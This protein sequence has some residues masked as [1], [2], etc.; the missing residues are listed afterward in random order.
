MV[1]AHFHR[2]LLLA[3]VP[4]P[5]SLVPPGPSRSPILLAHGA[6]L[7][8]AQCIA[9]AALLF[10]LCSAARVV[11]PPLSCTFPLVSFKL[12]SLYSVGIFRVSHSS[13]SPRHFRD[14]S[15]IPSQSCSPTIRPGRFPYL[16]PRGASSFLVLHP[17]CSLLERVLSIATF[18]SRQTVHLQSSATARSG[19]CSSGLTRSIYCSKTSIAVLSSLLL[20]TPR[21]SPSTKFIPTT[22]HLAYLPTDRSTRPS[23]PFPETSV[24][25]L[26]ATLRAASNYRFCK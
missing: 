19:P 11:G 1:C 25:L 12:F 21:H 3:S 14:P 16:C 22:F 23:S 18:F 10:A 5:S 20:P 9:A 15:W 24:A 4:V 8:A 17:L 26:A 6:L 7:N 13:S 2:S